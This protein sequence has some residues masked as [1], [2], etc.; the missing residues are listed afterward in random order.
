M[1]ISKA[2]LHERFLFLNKCK[3]VIAVRVSDSSL[4]HLFLTKIKQMKV[5]LTKPIGDRG[6]DVLTKAKLDI[7]V[8]KQKNAL[9]Q[10]ELIKKLQSFDAFIC[11]FQY[12]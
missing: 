3:N 2:A 8:W 5:F 9:S 6:M 4:L 10:D 7:T 12:R 11:I 1:Q